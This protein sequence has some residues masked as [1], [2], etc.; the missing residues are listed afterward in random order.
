VRLLRQ[1]DT[2]GVGV[3]KARFV[4]SHEAQCPLMGIEEVEKIIADLETA[5]A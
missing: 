4:A 3:K 2:G 1:P 5:L